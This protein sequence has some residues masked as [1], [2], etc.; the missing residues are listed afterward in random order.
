ME[1]SQSLPRVPLDPM[2]MVR[3]DP[4]IRCC[5][6]ARLRNLVAPDIVYE[7][8]RVFVFRVR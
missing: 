1:R 6:F 7:D 4:V 3:W 5:D 2:Y 8:E